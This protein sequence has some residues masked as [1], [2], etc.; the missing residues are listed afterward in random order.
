[1]GEDLTVSPQNANPLSCQPIQNH[2]ISFNWG[3]IAGLPNIIQPSLHWIRLP[4]RN[5]G[6]SHE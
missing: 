5:M 6:A 3:T 4:P 2:D 1:M